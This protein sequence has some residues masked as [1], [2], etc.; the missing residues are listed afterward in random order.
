MPSFLIDTGSLT[1]LHLLHLHTALDGR[2]LLGTE[3]G[4]S[5]SLALAETSA[6]ASLGLALCLLEINT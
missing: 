6:G 1:G 5:L 4:E 2:R 3:A